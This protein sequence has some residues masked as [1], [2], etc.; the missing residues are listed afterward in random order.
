MKLEKLLSYKPTLLKDAY[1]IPTKAMV[2]V[3]QVW[4]ERL[5]GKGRKDLHMVTLYCMQ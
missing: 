4:E 3:Y 2:F 1:K 5:F